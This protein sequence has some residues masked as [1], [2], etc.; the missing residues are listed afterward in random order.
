[1]RHLKPPPV[2]TRMDAD[3]NILQAV[4]ACE[5]GLLDRVLHLPRGLL[6]AN[7][8]QQACEFS[9]RIASLYPAAKIIFAVY[10]RKE[11]RRLR[12]DLATVIAE[13]VAMVFG[14]DCKHAGRC[15]V[16]TFRTLQRVSSADVDLLIIPDAQSALGHLVQQALKWQPLARTYGFL[17]ASTNL[18]MQER[19]TLEAFIGPEIYRAAPW[20]RRADVRVLRWEVPYAASGG[21]S[22]PLE[23]LQTMLW[24]NEQ[25]NRLIADLAYAFVRRDRN[26]LWDRGLL[27]ED[28]DL[29]G[30]VSGEGLLPVVI[31]VESVEHSKALSK[32]IS[33]A[34]RIQ[35]NPD[36]AGIIRIKPRSPRPKLPITIVTSTASTISYWTADIIIRASGEAC[37]LTSA[38]LPRVLSG[39]DERGQQMLIDLVNDFDEQEARLAARRRDAYLKN[40]WSLG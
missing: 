8:R 2:S 14:G 37:M 7:G 31:M 27:V 1:M 10:S 16:T 19:Q 39:D 33:E 25:R 12:H 13:D 32:K 15:T 30:L 18:D 40:G 22:A 11:G 24:R 4:A 36:A 17:F 21:F 35:K 20:P 9:A 34:T 3:E 26:R 23:R 29:P 5:R 38:N 28:T 6:V